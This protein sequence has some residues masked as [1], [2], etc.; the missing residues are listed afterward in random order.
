MCSAELNFTIADCLLNQ[1]IPD[2]EG[3]P[4]DDGRDLVTSIDM[5]V[6]G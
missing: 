1:R 5:I 6:Q 2:E 4:G 3:L